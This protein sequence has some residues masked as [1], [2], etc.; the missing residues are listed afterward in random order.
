M[1]SYIFSKGEGRGEESVS[2]RNSFRIRGLLGAHSQP[3]TTEEISNSPFSSLASH[4]DYIHKICFIACPYQK[5]LA[6][7]SRNYKG[8][9]NAL[10]F[11][12]INLERVDF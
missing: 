10:V 7:F 8:E 5:R 4:F 3:G 2:Y 11:I 6:G 1:G 12:F 9:T